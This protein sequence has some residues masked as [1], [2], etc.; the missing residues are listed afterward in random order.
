MLVFF[1]AIPRDREHI[2]RTMPYADAEKQREAVRAWRKAHPERVRE[3]RK[4]SMVKRAATERRLP[5]LS[6]IEHH[7]L[8]DEEVTQLVK[9][10][11]TVKYCRS[12]KDPPECIGP[13]VHSSLPV[14]GCAP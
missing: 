3:H 1:R 4:K 10:V 9:R 7:S 2:D 11:L 13:S 8:T 5:R 6:S 14:V 12:Y